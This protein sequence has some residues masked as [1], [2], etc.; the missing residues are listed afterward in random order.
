MASIQNIS[1]RVELLMLP[2][3]PK[4]ALHPLQWASHTH[5]LKEV[6]ECITKRHFKKIQQTPLKLIS[7]FDF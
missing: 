2:L 6:F 4:H 5:S 1:H 3:P 7:K